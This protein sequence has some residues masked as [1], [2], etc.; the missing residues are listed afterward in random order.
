M[1]RMS[2]GLLAAVVAGS[3]AVTPP[4]N[5]GVRPDTCEPQMVAVDGSWSDCE[6]VTPD[7]P[8]KVNPP[9]EK[10]EK[11]A[12]LASKHRLRGTASYYSTCLDGSKTASGE[13]FRQKKFTAAH[14]TLPLGS[15]VDIRSIATG[16]IV[17]CRVNDRGPYTGG[18]VIDL[19]Q[20]AARAL[21]VDRSADRRVEMRIVA[22]P[23]EA[24]PEELT[25][26]WTPVSKVPESVVASNRK[27]AENAS[28]RA[29][30]RGLDEGGVTA[31]VGDAAKEK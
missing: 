2:F 25:A 19:S 20:A 24:P 29:E 14:L 10:I 4:A 1:R 31:V 17:R 3:M 27:P 30:D 7:V 12:G 8:N 26:N 21:G 9:A 6:A 18:F 28:A 23:G 16:K 22:L 13:T 5:A 11:Y 15:W